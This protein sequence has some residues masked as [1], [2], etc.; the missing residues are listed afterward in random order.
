MKL[1]WKFFWREKELKR[2]IAHMGFGLALAWGFAID[3]V[4]I[5]VIIWLLIS[6][7]FVA[8]FLSKRRTWVDKIILMLERE[9]DL[10]DIPLRGLIFYLLGIALTMILFEYEAALAG[11]IILAVSDSIGTLYGKYLGLWRIPWNKNKHMEGPIL[12]GFMAALMCMT[13]LPILPAVLGAYT[14]AFLDTVNWKV[15]KYEVDD[16]LLIPLLSAGVV[17]QLM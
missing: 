9:N 7:I 1:I 16:N 3:L 14:G 13:F 4:N 15:G 6:F 12:G 2:Q 11:I 10:F 8:I 5:Y 17:T